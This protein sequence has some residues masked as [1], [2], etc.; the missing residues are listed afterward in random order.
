MITVSRYASNPKGNCLNSKQKIQSLRALS[1][2]HFFFCSYTS[3]LIYYPFM[4]HTKN[5]FA[6]SV[7]LPQYS[8]ASPLIP[9][10]LIEV[11]NEGKIREL[12]PGY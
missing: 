2:N 8:K 10:I 11:C 4:F 9:L 6:E 7:P 5:P 1:A 3:S 12:N